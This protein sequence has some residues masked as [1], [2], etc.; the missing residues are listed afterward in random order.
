MK[1]TTVKLILI[2][3][4]VIPSCSFG[5]YIKPHTIGIIVKDIQESTTWYETVLELK[6]YK[7]M[8]FPEYDSLRIN[9]LKGNYFQLELM[10][11][12]TSFTINKYVDDYSINN[13][14]LIGFSKI[15]FSVPNIDIMYERIK[16]MNVTE[17]LGITDDKEFNIRYF[18]IKDLD[19]NML[20][21]IEQKPD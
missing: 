15:G 7:E 17:I 16:K 11:K 19:D 6:L 3:S 4:I 14:P 10:E 2:L 20:Q 5:Q 12:K 9:F 13:K 8:A 18:I 21:F 1:N